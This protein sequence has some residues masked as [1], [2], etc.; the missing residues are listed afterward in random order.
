MRKY[1]VLTATISALLLALISTP[2][3]A[4]V[5][6][7]GT[8]LCTTGV[9]SSQTPNFRITSGVVS[10]GAS[11][12]GAVVI[13]AGVT[14]IGNEAFSF[15]T[16]LT[17]ITIPASV[18]SI[19]NEAFHYATSL[20]SITIPDSVIS[21]GDDAFDSATSL[22]SITIP[23]SVTSIGDGAFGGATAL[24][25]ITIPASV[26]SIR[27]SAFENATAL[28]SVYFLGTAPTAGFCAFCSVAAGAKAY[29]KTGATGFVDIGSD[30]NNLTVAIGVYS[31]T[32]DSSGG[33]AVASGAFIKDGDISQAP[34]QPTKS[35]YTF[36]GWSATDGGSA[37]TFP[38]TPTSNSD[39]T[40]YATW[41]VIAATPDSTASP[42]PS[43]SSASPSASPLEERSKA[44][45]VVES[46][47]PSLEASESAA[48]TVKPSDSTSIGAATE[49]QNATASQE[50][51]YGQA[52]WWLMVILILI[53]LYFV[54]R[55]Q[56]RKR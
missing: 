20:T 11:C 41:S 14:S 47:P 15:A 3:N 53:S 40:L 6:G 17:S 21:I 37:L 30:W 9:Q 12:A 24:T 52:L 33:S 25:S 50:Y 48:S 22:T 8:Y 5:P 23:A 26:T 39:L 4:S 19:G 16:S 34:T 38:Y 10:D 46:A 44:S 43:A 49:S 45:V 42:S 1:S 27:D 7:D 35:G 32:Y 55:T 2:A 18:T 13:P 29:I 28:T 54:L 51:G 31:V 36:T 56:R